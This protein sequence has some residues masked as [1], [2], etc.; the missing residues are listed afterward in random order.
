MIVIVCYIECVVFGNFVWN[1]CVVVLDWFVFV[2]FESGVFNL[3]CG[4][5]YILDEVCGKGI[6]VSDYNWS[7][8]GIGEG[9]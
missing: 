1:V 3:G 4:G 6:G 2:V 7:G 9:V 8:G 5:G